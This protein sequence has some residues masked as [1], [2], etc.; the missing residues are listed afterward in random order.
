MSD[1]FSDTKVMYL[2]FGGGGD[3]FLHNR[4]AQIKTWVQNVAAPSEVIYMCGS[5]EVQ[6]ATLSNR[7]LTL[8]ISEDYENGL[9]R[10]LLA[11]QWVIRERNFDWIVFSNTSNYFNHDLLLKLCGKLSPKEVHAVQGVWKGDSNSF[12]TYP[13]GAG[14]LISREIANRI[15][16]FPVNILKEY[17]N[18]VALGFILSE[19][20]V[21]IREMKRIDITDWKKYETGFHYRVKHWQLYRVTSWRM[22]ALFHIQSNEKVRKFLWI[23]ILNSSQFALRSFSL[24]LRLIARIKNFI[25]QSS[26][27]S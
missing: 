20:G 21:A 27:H 9:E 19:I 4:N 17:P 23:S 14:S 26:P 2:L 5:Q 24:F 25:S 15:A 13:S 3:K 12:I 18:D 22:H 10:Q 6:S 11:L 16:E 7:I 1:N 8:P